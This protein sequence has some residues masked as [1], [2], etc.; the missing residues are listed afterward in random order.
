MSTEFPLQVVATADLPMEHGVADGFPEA[1]TANT[2]GA[3][4]PKSKRR[5]TQ[6][7][8]AQRKREKKKEAD[9]DNP[10]KEKERKGRETAARKQRVGYNTPYAQTSRKRP[11]QQSGCVCESTFIEWNL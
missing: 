7:E 3:L 10:A 1:A 4:T 6:R 9:K 5:K 8:Y 11:R 2:E